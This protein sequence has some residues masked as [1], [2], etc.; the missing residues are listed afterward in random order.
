MRK[1]KTRTLETR[2]DA[3]P[4]TV[5]TG[6]LSA[7]RQRADLLKSLCFTITSGDTLHMMCVLRSSLTSTALWRY[8]SFC[9]TP[10]T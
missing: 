5:L 4:K 7:T 6:G 2:E 8:A 10:S 1:D 9:L 3:A